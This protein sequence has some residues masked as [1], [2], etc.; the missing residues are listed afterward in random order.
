MVSQGK[1]RE[2]YTGLTKKAAYFALS[3]YYL[4][5]V[6]FAPGQ[7]L[8]DIGLKTRGWGNVSVENNHIDVFIFEFAS[9]LNWLSKEYSEPRFSQFAEVI[10]TSMRQLLPYEGHLCRCV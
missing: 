1:E 10:S 8:G 5:D 9:I 4:W 3:W 2:H 6:P 7:M